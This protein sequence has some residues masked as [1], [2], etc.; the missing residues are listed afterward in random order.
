MEDKQ[1]L[2]TTTKTLEIKKIKGLVGKKT[3][4]VI[5]K[6]TCIIEIEKIKGIIKLK[7]INFANGKSRQIVKIVLRL[8]KA[9][10]A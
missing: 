1:I 10:I 6:K 9:R 7:A 3:A 2:V 8:Y 4:I 5:R